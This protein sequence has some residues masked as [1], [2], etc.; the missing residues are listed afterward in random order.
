M[1]QALGCPCDH[2]LHTRTLSKSHTQALA[3]AFRKSGFI[4]AKECY[5]PFNDTP[6]LLLA[7]YD[8][9]AERVVAMGESTGDKAFLDLAD[10]VDRVVQ[11][12]AFIR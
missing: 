3:E 7:L 2:A 4:K 9:E 1:F 6:R 8:G 12:G 10:L 11:T 5:E